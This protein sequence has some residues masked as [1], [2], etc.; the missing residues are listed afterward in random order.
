MNGY[1]RVVIAGNLT[2]QPELKYTPSGT[3]VAKFGVAMNRKWKDDQGNLQEAVTFVDVTAWAKQAET[4]TKHVDKGR[5]I[6]IEGRLELDQWEDKASGE[7]RSKLYVVLE[8]FVFLNDGKG[9]AE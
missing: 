1:N 8:Q 7:K 5:P 2:R 9:G 4:L 6:L 3:A